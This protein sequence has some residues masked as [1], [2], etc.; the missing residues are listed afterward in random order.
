[1]SNAG[2]DIWGKATNFFDQGFQTYGQP[3]Q[4]GFRPDQTDAFAQL[5]QY[6]GGYNDPT[7]QATDMMT[8][9]ATAPAQSIDTER[10]V[11]EGGRL[12]R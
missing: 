8:S 7:G 11:D 6:V 1:M 9:G 12:G 3:R 5:R 4:A 10:I 2:Q